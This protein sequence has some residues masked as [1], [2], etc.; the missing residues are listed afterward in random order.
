MAEKI[1]PD[2]GKIYFHL[3]ACFESKYHE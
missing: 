3:F 2:E 1:G